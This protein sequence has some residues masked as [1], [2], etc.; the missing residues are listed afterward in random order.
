MLEKFDMLLKAGNKKAKYVNNTY[1]FFEKEFA[2]NTVVSTLSTGGNGGGVL[3]NLDSG[4]LR[5]IS[6]KYGIDFLTE[7]YNSNIESRERHMFVIALQLIYKQN[8]IK[9]KELIRKLEDY[10]FEAVP[11]MSKEMVRE[12]IIRIWNKGRK[13]NNR[14]AI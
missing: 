2:L 7:I 12:K 6:K 1:L 10:G 11:K 5:L 4:D 13:R 8:D 9:L 14:I 3:K